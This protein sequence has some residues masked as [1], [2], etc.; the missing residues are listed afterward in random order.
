MRFRDECPAPPGTQNPTPPGRVGAASHGAGVSLQERLANLLLTTHPQQRIRL[1]MCLLAA[2][3]MLCCICAMYLVAWAGLAPLAAVHQWTVFACSIFL[4]A[5]VLI[6]SGYSRRWRDPAL[7]LFQNVAAMACVAWAYVITESARG[8]VLPVLAVI[9]MFGVFGL[10][11]RQM[12]SVLVYGL[13]LFGA[14]IALVHWREPHDN[15][16]LTLALAYLIVTGMVLLGSTVLNMRAHAARETLQRQKRQLALA[17]EQV[18]EL[19][20]RDEL[21]GLPNR[22]FMMEML[23]L[24]LEHAR[25]SGRHLLVALLDLDHFKDVNDTHG[26]AVGDVVLRAF[27]Q[28]VTG[29]VR[30]SDVLARWGGEE[31]VLLM[32]HTTP[33]EGARVLERV[34]AAAAQQAPL[35]DG[36]GVRLTVS[37]GAARLHPGEAMDALLQRADAALY[38]AKRQGRDRVVWADRDA[39]EKIA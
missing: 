25:R 20:T 29:C 5:Y 4:V 32:A 28:R 3:L 23:R 35:P 34:L 19:A 37:I 2:T 26:H 6:R 10:T 15:Q 36:S 24:E 1:G 39:P 22:R 38:A 11:P 13:V 8:V 18:R 31:F 9:L 12:V 16:P 30:A 33:A 27:A 14:T 7:T 21:T 17:V